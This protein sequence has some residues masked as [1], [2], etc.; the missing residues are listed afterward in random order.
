VGVFALNIIM[1][2]IEWIML[3]AGVVVTYTKI[4]FVIDPQDTFLDIFD[5]DL[6]EPLANSIV[7]S[8]NFLFFVVGVLPIYDAFNKDFRMCA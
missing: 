6:T 3:F 2:N 4:F 7:R 8:W 1:K 5:S